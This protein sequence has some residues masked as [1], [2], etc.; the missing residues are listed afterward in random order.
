[1]RPGGADRAGARHAVGR[2][3]ARDELRPDHG[4]VARRRSRA[5]AA[6]HRRHRPRGRRRGLELRPL[7]AARRGGDGEGLRPDRRAAARASRPGCSRPPRRTSSSRTGASRV[8]GTDRAVGLFEVAAAALRADAPEA[9]R[10]PLVGVARRDHER[11][12]LRLR[13]RGVRGRDRSRRRAWSRS[14][15]TRRSTTSAAPSIRCSSTARPTAASPQGVGQALVGALRLRA[16]DRAAAVRDVHG[17]RDAARRHA[18]VVHDRDQRGAVDVQ[19]A[20]PARRQRRRHDPGA[21]RSVGNAVVDALAD[22][23][24][25]HVELPATPERVWNAIRAARR[26]A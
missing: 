17:L 20:R 14:R 7:D 1:M 11:A 21:R 23:G 24:V 19:P 12:V 25:E 15:G 22:L 9:L 18:A 16:G 10:G 13:L 4:R 3:G 5:G 6:H 2:P 26:P 8:K